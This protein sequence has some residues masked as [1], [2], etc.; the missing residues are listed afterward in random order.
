M[1]TY[2]VDQRSGSIQTRFGPVPASAENLQIS[3]HVYN[4]VRGALQT[5]FG[6]PAPVSR[7]VA[8]SVETMREQFL[9]TR[10]A[11]IGAGHE[12]VPASV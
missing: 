2:H 9:D 10:A 6:N 1:N 4:D 8:H 11:L 3:A 5:V 7:C 12:D